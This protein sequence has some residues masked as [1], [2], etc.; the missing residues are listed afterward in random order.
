[1][2]HCAEVYQP[3]TPKGEYILRMFKILTFSS[4][5][6]DFQAY[7]GCTPL[8]GSGVLKQKH[9]AKFKAKIL[10]PTILGYSLAGTSLQTCTNIFASLTHEQR[11]NIEQTHVRNVLILVQVW[12]VYQR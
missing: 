2:L 1:M 7:V 10:R 6:V 8:Q 3:L 5:G 4:K 9:D 11:E 12:R